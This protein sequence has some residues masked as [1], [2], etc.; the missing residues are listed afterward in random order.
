VCVCVCVCV[1]VCVCVCNE[2]QREE[3]A[4]QGSMCQSGPGYV[5]ALVHDMFVV[6]QPENVQVK[7]APAGPHA[8]LDA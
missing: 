5:L 6:S 7:H 1:Y 8:V 3:H 4:E 2:R